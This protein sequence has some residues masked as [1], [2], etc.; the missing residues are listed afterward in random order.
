MK[1][2][3]PRRCEQGLG[4]LR[5]SAP[6]GSTWIAIVLASVAMVMPTGCGPR[7]TSASGTVTFA[8][9]LMKTGLVILV[10]DDGRA[11]TP[12]AVQPDGT[13]VIPIAPI[14]RAR[15]AF[16]NP[17]PPGWSPP[18]RKPASAATDAKAEEA[19]DRDAELRHLLDTAASFVE[20]PARYRDPATSGITLELKPGHNPNCTIR[21][22]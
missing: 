20:T 17:L 12:A 11:T 4:R 2:L 5:A 22:E 1:R 19:A 7:T 18:R 16:D 13:Y 14:G 3:T 6:V 15:V 8:G 9:K 10:G 21:L